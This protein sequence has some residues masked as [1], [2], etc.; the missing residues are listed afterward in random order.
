MP[1]I[2]TISQI[3]PTLN[4]PP[5][6]S[7]CGVCSGVHKYNDTQKQ[8]CDFTPAGNPIIPNSTSVLPPEARTIGNPHGTTLSPVIGQFTPNYFNPPNVPQY[9]KKFAPKDVL[10]CKP[11]MNPIV[12]RPPTRANPTPPN[13]YQPTNPTQI[14]YPTPCNHPTYFNN[15]DTNNGNSTLL[16]LKLLFRQGGNVGNPEPLD[17]SAP[18]LGMSTPIDNTPSILNAGKYRSAVTPNDLCALQ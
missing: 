15:F 14:G 3:P 12:T 9:A 2:L 5:A 6:E 16:P 1:S 18:Q 13:N 10:P 4:L 17:L 7:G 8:P 11:V